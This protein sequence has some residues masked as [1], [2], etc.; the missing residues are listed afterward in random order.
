MSKI[1][2]PIL[3][4]TGE[5][6]KI[7]VKPNAKKAD[8]SPG[9][10][11]ATTLRVSVPE[12]AVHNKANKAV[13]K[14]IKKQMKATVMITSGATSKSKQIEVLK[15]NEDLVAQQVSLF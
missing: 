2:P 13:V 8:V 4:K 7:T 5:S 6:Y 11:A 10:H 14:L 12:P 3:L 9:R 1:D 15:G